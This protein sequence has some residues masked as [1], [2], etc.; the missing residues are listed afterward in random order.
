MNGALDARQLLDEQR[1]AFQA[2]AGVDARVRRERLTRAIALLVDHQVDICE[3]LTHDFGRR[4]A[5]LTRFVDILPAIS[6]L[7]HARA[8]VSRWMWPR[9]RRNGRRAERV[10]KWLIRP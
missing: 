1:A 4:P 9:R 6:S 5:T 10:L 7:K 2:E 8:H 3:A